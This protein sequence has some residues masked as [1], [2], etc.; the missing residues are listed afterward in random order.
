MPV[1]PLSAERHTLSAVVSRPAPRKNP[2]TFANVLAQAQTDKAPFPLMSETY[3]VRRGDTLYGIARQLR[4]A[5]GLSK[6]PDQLVKEL[7]EINH[8]RNPN[9]IFPGQQLRLPPLVS[10]VPPVP[11]FPD[12]PPAQDIQPPLPTTSPGK[13]E[14]GPSEPPILISTGQELPAVRPDPEEELP[15]DP[16]PMPVGLD[17]RSLDTPLPSVAR[18]SRQ[19][20]TQIAMYKE[21]Q[22][23]A[24]PGGDYYFLN[25]ATEVY[26]PAF[27]RTQLAN[28]LGKDLADVRD[29]LLNMAKDLALGS[30]F[31]Y[32]GT[33]G[34]IQNG[35][36]V[37]LLGTMK[38]FFED[39]ISGLS[40]GAYVPA[41]EETPKGVGA[42]L[43]HFAKKIFYEAPV[44]DLLVGVPQ[45]AV[46]IGK[47][48]A[49]A[50][51]N[52]MQ[53]VPDA[54]ISNFD[55]GQ[56]LTTTVFDNGQVMVDY[57]TDILPGGDAWLRVHALEVGDE[58]VPPVLYNLQTAEQGVTDS[59][60]TTVRNTPFR[61]TIE[62]LGSLLADSMLILTVTQQLPSPSDD[63]RRP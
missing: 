3:T 1:R 6:S 2:Y 15:S 21:D 47:D 58:V 48:A 27:D 23:L 20:A 10:S 38:N 28:R 56:K 4:A 13:V 34:K 33:D 60:W 37:G 53:A 52:L 39:L 16:P 55:W 19:L 43:W 59:R 5:R 25:G 31:K 22:L 18:P 17:S 62:T 9:R 32:V 30:R 50:A 49:F 36:R 7:T 63:Q 41:G 14:T 26:N 46:N 12:L 57:I 29:N 51:L 8:L 35:Q 61:K 11:D 54:T 40:F 45:A 24:H 42:S 44:K